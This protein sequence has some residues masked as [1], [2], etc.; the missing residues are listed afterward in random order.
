MKYGSL[1]TGI[2]GF[3]LGFD[4]AGMECT[5]QCEI[6]KYARAVLSKHWPNVERLEDV[7]Q[8]G[9]E[10]LGPVDLICGGFPCQDLSVAGKRAGLAGS[11]SGLWFEFARILGE[12]KPAWVVIENVPGLLSSNKGKDFAVILR[13][14]VKLG[15][16]VCWRVLNSQHFG[17]PQRRNRVFIVGHL[18]DGRAAEVLFESPCVCGDSAPSRKEGEEIAGT[19]GGSSQSGGFRTTDLDNSGAFIV[20]PLCHNGK[21]AGSATQQDAH[22]GMLVTTHQCTG[23]GWWKQSGVAQ[24]VQTG[25]R[26]V[27]ESNAVALTCGNRGISPDQAAAGMIQPAGAHVRRLTPTECERLQGFPDGWTDGQSDT[28]R[29]KMCGNAVTVPVAEWLGKR[30][31]P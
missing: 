9:K 19:F 24:T 31:N 20:G 17:V 25:C 14:L 27:H 18:G 6:D 26:G 5:W 7:Q 21:A 3:D 4:R 15:Y 23:H 12:L 11:K 10:N 1:F 16:G 13:G 30:I 28:Q 22:S 8:I 29:Y 2:G